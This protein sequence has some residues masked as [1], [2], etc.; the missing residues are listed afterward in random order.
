MKISPTIFYVDDDSDDLNFFKEASRQIGATV[1]LF[2]EGDK[3]LNALMNP[4]PQASVVFIDLNMPVKNGY[5][6]LKEIKAKDNLREIPVVIL[7][8]T[9]DSASISRSKSL[10][11][12]YY[13]QK[14]TSMMKLKKDIEFVLD[15]DWSSPSVGFIHK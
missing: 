14:P 6:V 7:S 9:N 8:T 11:A 10:G 12:S 2:D 1:E 15:I 3:M 5:D 13:I 4:P